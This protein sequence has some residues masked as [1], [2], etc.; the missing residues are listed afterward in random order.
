MITL[1]LNNPVCIGKRA[2]HCRRIPHNHSNTRMHWSEKA[3][4]NDAWKREVGYT[5]LALRPLG[6]KL[7]LKFAKIRVILHVNKLFD[8][9]GAYTAVKPLIDALKVKDGVGIIEDDSPKYIDLMVDQVN[10][11]R[12]KDEK[13]IIQISY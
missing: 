3:L 12:R 2:L 6:L 10:V 4:W 5:W 13:V 8:H 7:P 1:T 11:K 9:D